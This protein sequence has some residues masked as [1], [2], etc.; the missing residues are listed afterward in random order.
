VPQFLQKRLNN[1]PRI[2]VQWR[3]N[4]MFCPQCGTQS[5]DEL[6]F[7]RTCGANLR[8]IGKAVTLSEAIAR[9]DSVP[10]K[11]K[12]LV[13][14]LKIEKVTDEVARAMEKVG[15][16][17]SHTAGDHHQWIQARERH[18][19]RREL[20]RRRK[21]KT[22]DQRRESLLTRGF[23]TMFSGIGL[24]AFLYVIG[25]SVVLNL[26]P[27]DI[28]KIPFDLYSLLHVL[29]LIGLIPTLAGFGRIMAGLSIKR[30]RSNQIETSDDQPLRIAEPGATPFVSTPPFSAG[31][32]NEATVFAT[33]QPQDSVT[34]RT[35]N[36]LDHRAPASPTGEIE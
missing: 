23:I 27:D 32:D 3:G 33:R 7:C 1:F 31:Q 18:E 10:A 2:G 21:E 25:H 26:S 13:K 35:T 16:E 14:N 6:K 9:S 12:D 24:G 20:R 5:S 8:V 11:V 28:S 22:A 4:A 36:I 15:Q 19:V 17:I 29:W 34:D 30:G